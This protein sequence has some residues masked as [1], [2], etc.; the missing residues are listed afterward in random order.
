[1]KL[2]SISAL[3]ISSGLS[4]IY[5]FV[6]NTYFHQQSDVWWQSL[7]F[8]VILFVVFNLLYFVRTDAKTYTGILLASGILK[9]LLSSILLLIYSFTQKGGFLPFA[10]HFI[11]HYVLFTVFEI[12]YLLQLIK[13]KKNEN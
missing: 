6:L 3:L 11:G 5:S 13:T 4:C 10:L 1:M 7:L 8:F 12:R 9:F 2:K